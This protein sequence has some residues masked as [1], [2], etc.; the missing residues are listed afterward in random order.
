MSVI[1]LFPGEVHSLSLN[2][3][4]CTN[5][6]TD[7]TET[8][9]FVDNWTSGQSHL[10][11]RLL[12]CKLIAHHSGDR[13]TKRP[14][15]GMRVLDLERTLVYLEQR[16]SQTNFGVC[17]KQM[18]SLCMLC[19]CVFSTELCF[20]F[21]NLLVSHLGNL[22]CMRMHPYYFTLGSKGY[23]NLSLEFAITNFD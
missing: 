20:L 6:A 23:I 4:D 13:G 12:Y 7:S 5:H 22:R 3:C 16:V 14:G 10:P 9:S 21:W 19:T 17:T 1:L 8:A 2:S 18:P 15:N 11:H